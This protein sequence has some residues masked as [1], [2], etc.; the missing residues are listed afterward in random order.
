MNDTTQT[1]TVE[2]LMNYYSGDTAPDHD[3]PPADE[4]GD[5]PADYRDE[6][7]CELPPATTYPDGTTDGIGDLDRQAAERLIKRYHRLSIEEREAAAFIDA[8]IAEAAAALKALQD[9]RAELLRPIERH[10]AWLDQFKGLLEAWAR[11]ALEGNRERSIKLAYGAVKFHK[12]QDRLEVRDEEAAYNWA[13][14]NAHDAIDYSL[15]KSVFRDHIRI[16]GEVPDGCEL[17]P[18]EDTFSLEVAP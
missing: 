13:T 17:V 12:G 10:R 11:T 16:T 6:V 15:K 8:E 14:Q 5:I 9:R 4:W 1:I 7:Y 18:G 3:A 2:D